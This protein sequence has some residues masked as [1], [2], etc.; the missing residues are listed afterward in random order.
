LAHALSDV[1]QASPNGRWSD[2]WVRLG[3]AA[4]LGPIALFCVWH[5]GRFWELFVGAALLGLGAEWTRLARVGQSALL[6]C[7]LLAVW[8]CEIKG[9]WLPGLLAVLVMTGIACLATGWFP[10]AGIPYAGIGGVALLWL[11]LQPHH[12]LADTMFLIVTIWGTDVGAYLVG[13][14]VGGA[15]LAPKVSPGKTWSGAI[16]GLLIGGF[17]GAMLAGDAHGINFAAL[18]AAFLLSFFA[19]GGDLLESAIKRKLGVK[20][21]GRTIPGHGGLFD[22]LDG[23]LAAAPVAAILALSVHGGLPLWG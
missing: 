12:G 4:I 23:F 14:V 16:G 7:L 8:V 5:G 2:F 22:R 10:A 18:P 1:A 6:P 13:R 19:Q 20:D 9:G 11:R 17:A 15:K 3:S 21:S